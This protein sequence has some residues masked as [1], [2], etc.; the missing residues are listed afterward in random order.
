MKFRFSHLALAALLGVFAATGSADDSPENAKQAARE[1]AFID[2]LS[3]KTMV[4]SFSIDGRDD[5]SAR[6][7]RYEIG[8]VKKLEGGVWTIEARI[9]YGKVD[10]KVPVPVKVDWAGETPMIIVDD[11][12][13]PLVG[14]EFA[15]RVLFHG[16]RYAGT[17]QHGDVGGHM[18][19]KIED[20]PPSPA[21]PDAGQ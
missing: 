10:A 3:G 13:L 19:G 18:W 4:G 16:D 9:V 11:L 7:E 20:T 1:Q 8:D 15:A 12:S 5:T 14:S 17:W 21:T 2:L 6:P